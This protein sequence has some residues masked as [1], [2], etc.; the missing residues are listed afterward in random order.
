MWSG[1]PIG[2]AEADPRRRD[3]PSEAIGEHR[4]MYGRS[5]LGKAG[6]TETASFFSA[7]NAIALLELWQAITAWPDAATRRKLNFAFTA[8]LARASRRYQWSAKRPLN[9]QNQTYYIAPVYYEWNVFEL[10]NRKVRATLHADRLLFGAGESRGFGRSGAKDVTYELA[11]ADAL[12]HLAAQSVDY[13]FTDPPFGSNIFYSDMSLFHEAWLGRKTDD[14]RE[15][16]LH[17]TGKRKNGAAARYATL[18]QGAFAEAHRVLKPGRCMS[19]VFGNSNGRV[20]GLVQRALRDA[21][22]TAPPVHVVILD[23]GQRSVKGLNSGSEGVVTV[24]LILTVR[25]GGPTGSRP[26]G[27]CLKRMRPDWF[28][29]WSRRCQGIRRAIRVTCTRT[30]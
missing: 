22:F 20:W 17:T 16:V 6:L 18:L 10:F 28:V 25:K 11:S 9:A 15:A 7:R 21:G 13:V 23:K 30:S 5:G 12:K 8:I 4:E 14:E 19:V 29:K 1:A 3:V 26:V 24:D 2:T 27:R